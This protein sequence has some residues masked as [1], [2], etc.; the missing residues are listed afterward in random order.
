MIEFVTNNILDSNCE[1]IINTVNCVGVSGKGL[2]FQFKMKYPDMFRAYKKAC[3]N[4]E[5]KIGKM[6]LWKE[7]DK[8]IINFPT[9]EHWKN[10]SKIEWITEGLQDLVKIIKEN[11]IQS[12]AIPALGCQN[13][14]LQYSLV[15]K[16]I[17]KVH[18]EYWQD[19]K[20]VCYLPVG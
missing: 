20:V 8:W 2:A 1:A 15:K 3:D 6:N 17:E 5:V 11:N 7:N 18:D 16:E 9:K 13:G 14:R 12:V 19:I 10:S 4:N